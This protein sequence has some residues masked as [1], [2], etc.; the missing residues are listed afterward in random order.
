M[1][2]SKKGMPLI[3]CFKCQGLIATLRQWVRGVGLLL[4]KRKDG[5][6]T[7]FI[8]FMG[9]VAKWRYSISYTFVPF[10]L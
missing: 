9:A 4:I 6:S 5:G 2:L 3:N 7:A 1:E 10:V 8:A